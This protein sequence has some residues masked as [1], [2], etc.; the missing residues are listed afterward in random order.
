MDGR[1]SQEGLCTNP[2]RS[3]T[4]SASREPASRAMT[5]L[6]VLLENHY[7]GSH[8]QIGTTRI[9]D[10]SETATVLSSS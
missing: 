9:E 2:R 6:I 8:R 1:S 4:A 3:M 10:A 7:S 5:A